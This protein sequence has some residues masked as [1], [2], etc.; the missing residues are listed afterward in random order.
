MIEVGFLFDDNSSSINAEKLMS[1]GHI[2]R[3]ITSV[4]YFK[5]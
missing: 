3:H 1:V 2:T 4:H 5:L